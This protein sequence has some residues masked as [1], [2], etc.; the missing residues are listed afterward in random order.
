MADRVRSKD[1]RRETE[2][3]LGGRPETPGAQ[4]RTGG[5]LARE[6]GT[7]DILKREGGGSGST[8]PTKEQSTPEPDHGNGGRAA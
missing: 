2:D 7:R 4:G 8:G 3:Y 6:V 5:D 1:G